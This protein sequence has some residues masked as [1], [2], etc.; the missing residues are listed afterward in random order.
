MKITFFNHKPHVISMLILDN[1]GSL[2]AVTSE[3]F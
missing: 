2:D 3:D 1:R